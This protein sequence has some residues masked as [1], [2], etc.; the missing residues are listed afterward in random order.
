MARYF[1]DTGALLGITFL[2]DLWRDEAERLFET[3]NTLYT[4]RAVIY[5]YCNSDRSNSLETADVNWES[6]EGR[7][8]EK[9][10]KVRAAQVNLDL[11]LSTYDDDELDLETLVD[12]F[13]SE[14]GIEDEIYPQSKIDEYIR[15][16]IRAF[17]VDEIGDREITREVARE[18]MDALCD[19]IQTEARDT[20]DRLRRR[21]KEGPERQT[22]WAEQ[23]QR[24]SFVDGYVDKVIL[25]DAGHMADK[26]LLERVIT[27]DKGDIYEHREQIDAILGL[28]ILFIKDEFA[29]PT[30]AV[31]SERDSVERKTD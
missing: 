13:I 18:A 24:L 31:Q 15:P 14:T 4:S 11:K 9:F 19:T 22:E 3:D 28:R 26:N 10:S 23:R 8:G 1:L 16:N 27:A 21:I 2:H 6:E 12:A 25:C 7:F 17:L 30:L 20:R 29:E 5:E